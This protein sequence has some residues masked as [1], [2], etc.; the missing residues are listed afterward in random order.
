MA[1]ILSNSPPMRLLLPTRIPVVPSTRT[2]A[3]IWILFSIASAQTPSDKP[4]LCAIQGQVLQALGNKPI[5]KVTVQLTSSTQ[6]DDV[7]Y[8]ATTDAEGKFRIAEIKAGTYQLSA[9]HP[10]FLFVDSK[11]KVLR[12]QKL[13]L[14]PSDELED[15]VLRMLPSGVIAGKIVDRDGDPIPSVTVTATRLY[16]GPAHTN[17]P[18]FARTNDQGEYRIP[19]LRPGQYLIAALS[20]RDDSDET[21]KPDSKEPVRDKPPER[22]YTTYYPSTSDQ[23]QAVPLEI[24]AGDEMPVNIS[25]QF[26]PTFRVRGSI[27]NLPADDADNDVI[28]VPKDASFLQDEYSAPEIRKDGSFEIRGVPPGQYYLALR[29]ATEASPQSTLVETVEVKDSDLDNLN[30]TP[31][32]VASIRGRFRTED[33][34]KNDWSGAFLLLASN[35]TDSDLWQKFTGHMSFDAR[36]NHDGSFEI[37]HVP[38]GTYQVTAWG[39]PGYGRDSFLKSV[40]IG[41]RDVTNSGFNVSGGTYSL[42]IVIGTQGAVIEGVVTESVDGKDQPA[43][44]EVIAIPTPARRKRDDSYQ[45]DTTDQQGRFT[46][47]GLAPGEYDLIA[48]ENRDEDYRAPEFLKKFEDSFSHVSV[49]N[50][51]HKTMSLKI[52]TAPGD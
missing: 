17:P 15:L 16:S 20:K 29:S 2:L 44:A 12:S 33:S 26:G 47:H 22:P 21:V 28:L 35:E 11:R 27:A 9:E 48:L 5:R 50:G 6:D 8:S 18:S 32:P 42:D 1:K 19:N 34:Q 4:K 10:G 37:Q 41:G 43:N 39:G 31:I 13:S 49:E 25:M 7:T 45:L 23:N 38:A 14:Q 24:H 3:A 40:A 51:G 36:V 52:A 30:I 46:L